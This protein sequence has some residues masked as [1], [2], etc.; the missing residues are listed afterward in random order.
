MPS[1]PAPVAVNDLVD[2]EVPEGPMAGRYRTRVEGLTD[3]RLALAAP[4]HLGARLQ[5]PPGTRVI[6]HVL[7]SD[8]ARGARFEGHTEV[9]A[10]REE[11]GV[12]MLV[13]AMPQW[14]RI[15]LRSWTR[16]NV[17]VPVRWRP[18]RRAD[19][20][21]LRWVET[22]SRDL[23]GGGL[24]IWATHPPGVGQLLSVAIELPE[25]TVEAVAEVVRVQAL[26]EDQGGG[27]GVALK[28]VEIAEPDR[29]RIIRFVL[30]RQAEMRRMGLL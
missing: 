17:M 24:V 11:N 4:I 29:D 19:R 14:Q 22:E 6:V 25:S 3:N 28:F 30:R 21:V 10:N 18:T 16:V 20:Q 8:P 1:E 9:L 13:L 26:G 27:F 23:G 12:L 7:R 2:M 15:Q 5:L